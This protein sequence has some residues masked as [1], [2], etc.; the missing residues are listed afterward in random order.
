MKPRP[1]PSR[2]DAVIA[3][4]DRLAAIE[5]EI[6]IGEP[7]G[8]IF[9]LWVQDAKAAGHRCPRCRTLKMPWQDAACAFQCRYESPR[10]PPARATDREDDRGADGPAAL[11]RESRIRPIEV[12]GAGRAG[13]AQAEVR[14]YR[15]VLVI[16]A[17]LARGRL[18]ADEHAAA[19]ALHQAW[20]AAGFDRRT[21]GL[22]G[23]AGGDGGST[24]ASAMWHGLVAKV[25]AEHRV[26]VVSVCG[27]NQQP[28][29]PR[30]ERA[31]KAGLACLAP[32]DSRPPDATIRA[33]WAG[34]PETREGG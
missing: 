8:A 11:A 33:A 30:A 6:S 2:L 1:Q 17:M 19:L 20:R 5:R 24:G 18:T 21:T 15:D 9:R 12:E 3:S 10:P 29:S 26:V 4:L 23:G 16:D 25:P 31:L 7:Q 27:A 14:E 13:Y 22:Y 28:T 32:R 34:P